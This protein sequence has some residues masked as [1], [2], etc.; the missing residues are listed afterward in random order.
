MVKVLQCMTLSLRV[1]GDRL[2]KRPSYRPGRVTLDLS[3]PELKIPLTA[4]LTLEAGINLYV[5]KT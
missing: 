4:L 1:D 2:R 3:G 5:K